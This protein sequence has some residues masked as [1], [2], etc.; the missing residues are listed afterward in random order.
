MCVCVCGVL[1]FLGHQA[2]RVAPAVGTWR[3]NHTPAADLA[4]SGELPSGVTEPPSTLDC[5]VRLPISF[6]GS[7][8]VRVNLVYRECL[9][10]ASVIS[11]EECRNE[12]AASTGCTD[13]G[14]KTQH[15]SRGRTGIYCC[16]IIC[17]TVNKGNAFIAQSP[18]FGS[19]VPTSPHTLTVKSCFKQAK[20]K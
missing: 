12:R 11:Q 18:A 14:R 15:G 6:P 16:V 20:I 13:T 10:S 2:W 1:D 4:S 19:S 5:C 17:Y 7:H 9:T 3:H 8:S